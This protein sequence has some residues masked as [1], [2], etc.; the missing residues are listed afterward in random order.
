MGK[1][2]THILDT[3]LGKPASHVQVQLEIFEN[4][5]WSVLAKTQ[6]NADGRIGNFLDAS[7]ETAAGTYRI[8]FELEEYHARM[9]RQPFY[10]YV[11]IVFQIDQP[12][13]NFHIPLIL[14]GFG[15]S[16]YRGS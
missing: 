4:D 13:E 10:P 12:F 11:H 16:T 15:Y 2:S 9:Q 14:N 7:K 3:I 5:R 8:T 1:I 6:T